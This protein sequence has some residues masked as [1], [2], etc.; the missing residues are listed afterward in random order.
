MVP[1][2]SEFVVQ[3][4]LRPFLC[5]SDVLNFLFAAVCVVELIHQ[6]SCTHGPIHAQQ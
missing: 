6:I 3:I 2:T 4:I 5:H 1:E